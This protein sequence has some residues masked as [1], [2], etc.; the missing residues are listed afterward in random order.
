MWPTS[1]PNH[2]SKITLVCQKVWLGSSPFNVFN[3]KPDLLQ[4]SI[5][6][7]KK[8][9]LWTSLFNLQCNQYQ[10]L[11]FK[12]VHSCASKI[13]VGFKSWEKS[14]QVIP[15]HDG[16]ICRSVI[17]IKPY[18]WN[19]QFFKKWRP[20]VLQLFVAFLQLC[21]QAWCA[22]CRTVIDIKRASNGYQIVSAPPCNCARW[23]QRK[24]LW[25]GSRKNVQ[26]SVFHR[27][28]C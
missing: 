20:H 16:A 6:A 26:E 11:I 23:K 27:T 22:I 1:E 5:P 18:H 24:G 2:Y 12:N 10:T 7:R 3:I 17:D 4:L 25:I 28:I 13:G 9:G 14:V 21:S 19:L 15:K 8:L